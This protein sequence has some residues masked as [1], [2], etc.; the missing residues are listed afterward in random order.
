VT[1]AVSTLTALRAQHV[2]LLAAGAA[3]VDPLRA[4]Y[5]GTLLARCQ[6]QRA[7][8]IRYLHARAARELAALAASVEQATSKAATVQVKAPE[9][10]PAREG[11]AALRQLLRQR[12][13]QQPL[14]RRQQF[15]AELRAQERA[16]FGAAETTIVA[17]GLAAA[18]R[19]RDLQ[20][21]QAADS[22]MV[23]F[24]A[25]LPESPGPLNP[26]ALVIRSL[27]TLQAISPAYLE[28]FLQY[29]RSLCWLRRVGTSL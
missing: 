10:A 29:S 3:A 4:H 19:F 28:H 13:T 23:G 20:A 6:G 1:V 12:Q 22:Q 27:V 2:R 25:A 26:Q 21:G 9:P 17:N 15:E 16:I 8:V 11:L 5:A 18:H 7:G 14:S 24:R